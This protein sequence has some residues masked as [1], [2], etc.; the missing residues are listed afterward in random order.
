MADEVDSKSI[1]GNT[2]RV[3][4]P[5]PADLKALENIGFP[6]FSRAFGVLEV[7][8]VNVKTGFLKVLCNTNATRKKNYFYITSHILD[9]TVL[10][11]PICCNHPAVRIKRIRLSVNLADCIMVVGVTTQ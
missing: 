10:C 1:G 8:H 5:Q 7:K 3:Q 2:V 6:L 4:V 11:Y 9:M